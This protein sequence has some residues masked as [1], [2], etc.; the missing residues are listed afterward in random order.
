MHFST[1]G[2]SYKKRVTIISSTETL[3]I[4]SE[5]Q[6]RCLLRSTDVHSLTAIFLLCYHGKWNTR[7]LRVSFL[8]L[9]PH[10]M[11]DTYLWL[12]N[13]PKIHNHIY[14]WS[15]LPYTVS[16]GQKN[17]LYSTKYQ[18]FKWFNLKS[19]EEIWVSESLEKAGLG[20]NADIQ[21]Q[22]MGPWSA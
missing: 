2:P 14:L 12:D 19:E 8:R 18:L 6:A 16:R 20:P 4:L 11:R 22:Q 3:E 1:S 5:W 10:S 15:Q 13:L 17:S 9:E 7:A 21:K